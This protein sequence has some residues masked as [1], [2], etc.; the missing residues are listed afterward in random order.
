MPTTREM[1]TE[2]ATAARVYTRDVPTASLIE[3][4][5][6]KGL[7]LADRK[8]ITQLAA[9]MHVHGFDKAKPIDVWKN[10]DGRG[11][12][13]VLDGHQR[14]AAARKAGLSEVHV[15][16]REPADRVAALLWAAAQQGA[17]RN[18]SREVQVLSV[19][20]A[21]WTEEGKF[22][23]TRELAALFKFA[24]ATIDRAKQLIQQGDDSEITAVLEGKH[25]L[26]K[27]YDSMLKRLNKTTRSA[28]KKQPPVI[29]ALRDVLGKAIAGGLID[30][31]D[32]LKQ[33]RVLYN[34]LDGQAPALADDDVDDEEA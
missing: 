7:F 23:T 27:G 3:D 25:G 13:V 19:L 4:P 17:R 8:L 29:T 5:L 9:N 31:L 21:L 20:R 28:P 2:P 10:G 18:A 24:P 6:F 15:V 12:H 16:Y 32:V 33:A 34:L 26:L 1:E 30:N 22:R 14:L 11:R